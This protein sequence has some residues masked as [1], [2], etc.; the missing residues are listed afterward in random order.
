MSFEIDW[1][2]LSDDTINNG[3]KEFLDEQFQ[4]IDLPS[5]I[6]GLKVTEFNLGTKPPDIIIRHISNPFDEFYDENLQDID[7]R[8]K[9]LSTK[10][11]HDRSSYMDS[12]DEDDNASTNI[13]TISEEFLKKDEQITLNTDNTFTGNFKQFP[14]IGGKTGFQ[15]EEEDNRT[16]KSSDSLSLMIGNNNVG[17]LHNHNINSL[18]LGNL[19]SPSSHNSTRADTPTHFLNHAQILR[20][21]RSSS[22]I[23]S[24]ETTS[25]RNESDIQLITEFNY[26]GDLHIEIMVNLLVNYPS[27][28]FISL[29]IKLQITDIVIH[30]IAVIAYL[31]KSVYVS[32]LCD[33][34]EQNSEYFT[35]NHHQT[36]TDGANFVEYVSNGNTQE[37]ID[38]IKKIK[39]ES[40]IG[41]VE[42][43]ALRNVGKVEKFLVDRLRGILRDE[44]AWPSWICLDLNEDTDDT[45]SF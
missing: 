23:R 34:N 10:Y 4:S 14:T 43:N 39:I 35:G 40:E 28:N 1:D 29:P 11:M 26:H 45:E 37:R 7:E 27:P 17:F 8:L 22:F 25:E 32:F 16:R 42:H 9:K 30:S 12:S 33:I 2:K 38:I 13:S 18:G 3:I 19:N 44:I 31:K 41:G 15:L 36:F 6:S 5:F 24:K 21:P 20:D